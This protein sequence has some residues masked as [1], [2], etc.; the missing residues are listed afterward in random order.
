[1]EHQLIKTLSHF[2]L[3]PKDWTVSFPVKRL[4][5]KI[6]ISHKRERDFNLVG[7]YNFYNNRPIFDKICLYSL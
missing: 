3:N 2:G 6:I 7:I 4:E 5:R 1:M